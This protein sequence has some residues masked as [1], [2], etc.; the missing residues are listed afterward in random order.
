MARPLALAALLLGLAGCASIERQARL[1]RYTEPIRQLALRSGRL[2]WDGLVIG[3]SFREAEPLAQARSDGRCGFRAV[4]AALRRQGLEL[5]FDD[6]SEGGRLKAIG[7]K[8]LNPAGEAS[9]AEIAETLK[10]RFP[11]VV[12][13]P[14]PQQPDLPES[15][16]PRPLYRTPNGALFLVDPRVGLYFGELCVG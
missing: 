6:R 12:Y 15:L 5:D 16:N 13:Q 1:P 14:S 3:M 10:A 8:L 9:G 4:N 2:A 11:E 7:L